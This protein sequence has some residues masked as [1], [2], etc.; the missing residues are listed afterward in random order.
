MLRKIIHY[1]I[2]FLV[3]IFFLFTV[4]LTYE[5]AYS[6][7]NQA[8]SHPNDLT[9]L[10]RPGCPRC[11]RVFPALLPK[12]LLSYKRDYLI[13]AN[14]LNNKELHS[15]NLRITPGFIYHK[16]TVQTINLRRINRI[17][18]KTHNF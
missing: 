2:G 6:P 14:K 7:L 9:I 13:D 18:E 17:W 8:L 10:Y 16:N 1:V 5:F 11:R 3:L 15:I 12:L 4:K